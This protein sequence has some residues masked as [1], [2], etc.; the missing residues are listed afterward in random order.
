MSIQRTTATIYGKA[1]DIA[2]IQFKD[3]IHCYT[4]LSNRRHKM[5]YALRNHKN[6]TK[7]LELARVIFI[8][9]SFRTGSYCFINL[10]STIGPYYGLTNALC[11]VTTP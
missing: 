8:Y 11:Y 9:W 10:Y 3:A 7:T 4:V 1:L 6:T 2:K 5:S